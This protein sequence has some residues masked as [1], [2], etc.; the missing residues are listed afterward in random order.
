MFLSWISVFS[1]FMYIYGSNGHL[2]QQCVA[3]TVDPFES[4]ELFEEATF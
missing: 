3:V 1:Y 2:M 4:N